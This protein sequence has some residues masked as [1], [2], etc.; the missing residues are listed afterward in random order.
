MERT[1][2]HEIVE[3]KNECLSVE[4][5]IASLEASPFQLTL[6]LRYNECYYNQVVINATWWY[7]K[8]N[9]PP[10]KK[11]EIHLVLYTVVVVEPKFYYN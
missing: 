7:L 3:N 11:Q 6:I 1:F 9:L 10:Y 5:L 8:Q 2:I 4:Y